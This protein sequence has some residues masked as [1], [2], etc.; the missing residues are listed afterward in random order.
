MTPFI[1]DSILQTT[2]S[3]L[4]M[5][6][7]PKYFH[8][9]HNPYFSPLQHTNNL[10][11]H[12][13]TTLEHLFLLI[14]FNH[15]IYNELNKHRR[16]KHINYHFRTMYNF[17]MLGHTIMSS[18]WFSHGTLT[19]TISISERG[20]QSNTYAKTLQPI[21]YLCHDAVTFPRLVC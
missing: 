3:F 17:I 4:S 15:K 16:I 1:K 7:L 2:N 13:F 10:L 12:T 14:S 20:T 8:Y 9:V 19:H 11:S 6:N 5:W 21:P 18:H